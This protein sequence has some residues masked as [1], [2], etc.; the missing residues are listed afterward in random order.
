MSGRLSRAFAILR[1]RR[2]TVLGV[3][4]V[5]ALVITGVWY[6]AFRDPGNKRITAYFTTAVGVYAGSDLRVL[7]VKVGSIDAVRP[8][9]RQV[10]VTMTLNRDETVPANAAAVVVAPSIVADRYIQLTPAYT[11]GPQ[12]AP[13]AVIPAD[14]T[15]TP[16]ELDQLYDSIRK[17][18][19][20]LGPNGANKKGALSDA[21]DVGAANLGGNGEKF[22][23]MIEEFGKA[24]K[25]L[26][27]SSDDLFATIDN[28]QK[29][30]TMLR[31]NDGQV[32]L[33]QQQLAQVTGFLAQDRDELAAALEEMAAALKKVKLFIETNRAL[34]RSNVRK[35]S[36]ITQVLVDQR[37][38]LA[39]ALDIQPLAADNLLN[40]YD[41][42]SRTLIGRG[43]LNEISMG[44]GVPTASAA[45][46]RSAGGA[47]SSAG[48]AG[49]VC[50]VAGA[51]AASGSLA[52]L[53]RRVPTGDLAPVSSARLGALPPLPLPP[54]GQVY[55]SAKAGR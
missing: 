47:G 2:N 34:I 21:L 46:A 40:A 32:Q 29:F 4:L 30:T 18:T 14:R 43:D 49:S 37:K 28:L 51:S 17:L 33:A 24:N 1:G 26:A 23:Q 11:G 54:V 5:L 22:G 3:A 36:S 13:G 19:T 12:I 8:E 31:D 53:C 42:G 10:R 39:E 52:S 15:A 16:V 45:A 27:G 38:S 35:L 48:A 20:A 50:A 9:G 44:G 55:G 41:P 7:G 6:A 25:T